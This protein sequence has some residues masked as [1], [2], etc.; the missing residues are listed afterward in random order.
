MKDEQKPKRHIA[1]QFNFV[2]DEPT[3]DLSIEAVQ[4]RREEAQREAVKK[5]STWSADE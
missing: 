4:K 5:A 1:E 3:V 2:F